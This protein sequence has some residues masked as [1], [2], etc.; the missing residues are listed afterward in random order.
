[1]IRFAA[2]EQHGTPAIRV[3]LPGTAMIVLVS[4]A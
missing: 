1:M 3:D 4:F 2:F